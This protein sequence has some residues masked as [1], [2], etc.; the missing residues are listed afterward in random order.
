MGHIKGRLG[1]HGAIGLQG[2]GTHIAG[3]VGRRIADIDLPAGDVEGAS[4]ERNRL[5]QARDGVLAGGV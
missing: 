1:R 5:G 2:A 3:H 4:I